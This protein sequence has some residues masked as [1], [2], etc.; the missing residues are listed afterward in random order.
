MTATSSSPSTK[1]TTA[2]T[3]G[4]CREKRPALSETTEQAVRRRREQA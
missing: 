4:R 1:K 3:K 2:Q